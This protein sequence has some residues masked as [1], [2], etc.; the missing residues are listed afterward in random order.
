MVTQG[1]SPGCEH[2]WP[3]HLVWTAFAIIV[4]STCR[5]WVRGVEHCRDG[6]SGDRVYGYDSSGSRCGRCDIFCGGPRFHSTHDV[7]R[8]RNKSMTPAG[9]K[10]PSIEPFPIHMPTLNELGRDLLHVSCIA[11][12]TD[13]RNAVCHDGWL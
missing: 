9:S 7:C 11:T 4:A 5:R 13:D 3:L 10:S 6:A 1:L 2:I 8:S 12:T